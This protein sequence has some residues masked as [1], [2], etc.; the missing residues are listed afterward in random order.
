MCVICF[1]FWYRFWY[2]DA[3]GKEAL[4]ALC[5]IVRAVLSVPGS[6]VACE[7]IWSSAGRAF[8]K[9]RGGLSAKTGGIQVF[10]HEILKVQGSIPFAGEHLHIR[11]LNK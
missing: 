2:R 4:L 5:L 10:L 9:A 3:E 8:T 7:R 11:G 1:H 6:A